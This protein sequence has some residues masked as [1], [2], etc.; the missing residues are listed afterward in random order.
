MR[1]KISYGRPVSE[2]R[3]EL[4]FRFNKIL[5]VVLKYMSMILDQEKRVIFDN[6]DQYINT[7]NFTSSDG[8][9]LDVL[10][11]RNYE[12]LKQAFIDLNDSKLKI[13]SW[14][15]NHAQQMID[16]LKV[17][18]ILQK[19]SIQNETLNEIRKFIDDKKLN[20]DVSGNQFGK[21]GKKTFVKRKSLWE[22]Q[23]S[24][25]AIAFVFFMFI[26]LL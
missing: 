16:F 6:Q 4:V 2:D 14:C 10:A 1:L 15:N 5:N 7:F 20:A 9:D 22:M 23:V 19:R 11:K 8:T 24:I 25:F 21:R 12:D 17:T 3:W 26:K 18:R 13:I